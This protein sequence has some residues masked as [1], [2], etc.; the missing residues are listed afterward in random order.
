M[1][2]II[3]FL[4][5]L[6]ASPLSALA[7]PETA[8]QVR[9]RRAKQKLEEN[10]R[11]QERQALSRELG[12]MPE[13][14]P[15]LV[16]DYTEMLDII[17]DQSMEGRSPGSQGIEEA[18]K[19]IESQLTALGLV[20]A[21][22]TTEESADGTEVITKNA[23]FRQQM[24]MGTHTAATTETLIIA[25]KHFEPGIDFSLLAYSGSASVTA[26]VTFAGYAIVS[27]P[28]NYLGFETNETVKDRIALVL[29]YEPMND[30]G[31]SQ[32]RDEDWSH[33]ARLTYKITALERRGAAA[34]ILVSPPNAKDDRAHIL[35]TIASTAPP[36]NRM[37]KRGG[38]QY[39]IPVIHVTA[40]V[41]RAI[42]AYTQ[43]DASIPHTLED[44]ITKAN[45]GGIVLPLGDDQSENEISLDI[46]LERT[47]KWTSNIGAILPGKGNLKDEYV[48]IG[49]HYDHLGY[50]QFGSRI[51]DRK[52]K[53][54]PGAD[55]N[56]SGTTANIL[57][58]KTLTKQY[59]LLADT[60]DARSILFLWFTAEESGLNGSKFYV[61]HPIAPLGDHVVM[62][63]LDMIGTLSDGLLEIGGLN[64][65]KGFDDY[66]EPFLKQAAIPY[67]TDSSVGDGRSDHASF[68]A[69]GIPNLF[70]FTG[71]HERYHAPEDTVEFIDFEG[72]VRVSL[73]VSAMAKDA[74]TRTER[75]VHPMAKHK[76]DK[77]EKDGPNVRVGIIPANSSKPGMEVQRVFDD[78]S[79]SA[80]GLQAG[81]RIIKWNGQ[82]LDSVEAWMPILTAQEPGD[83]VTLTII[84][85]DETIE[86]KMTLRAIE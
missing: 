21:F 60:Q 11:N 33:N 70:F 75:L 71:L 51:P 13:I 69:V 85:D 64:S 29:N 78:T 18:A 20:P 59:Q 79:A 62:L 80:A 81:D 37:G 2:R 45:E 8:A 31:S 38:P 49:S 14:D 27:G 42:L 63:N 67:T 72:A 30:D 40:E 57:A 68:D 84:R 16:D 53:L 3:L 54:H 25:D 12:E 23:T 32:W 10:A 50:G 1:L 61:K 65:A 76:A 46:E 15:A 77:P 44:L 35:E 56:G 43:A 34:V 6:F 36:A 24:Q 74:A 17:A 86:L 7:G 5:I 58:A 26:P 41:A 47:P 4:A 73:L 9:E 19:Y 83:Q 39:D 22:A 55:D 28:N 48:V 82:N 52:G 66:A